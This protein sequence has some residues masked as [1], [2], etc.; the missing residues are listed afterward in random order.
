MR[1]AE[2]TVRNKDPV[3]LLKHL[4]VTVKGER[5]VYG[6]FVTQSGLANVQKQV[7]NSLQPG[8]MALY[9]E[10]KLLNLQA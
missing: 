1:T 3:E 2:A 6:D 7:L 10:N 5:P 4:L 8:L 9:K